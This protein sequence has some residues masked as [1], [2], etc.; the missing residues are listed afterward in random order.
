MTANTDR[1]PSLTTIVI[2][3]SRCLT[4]RAY[5]LLLPEIKNG[6]PL[7]DNYLRLYKYFEKD[8]SDHNR[9]Q[10]AQNQLYTLWQKHF[11]FN[12]FLAKF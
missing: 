2:Y 12:I 8:F 1:F 6:I 7:F 11:D 10:N 5:Q 3:I 9:A 4:R